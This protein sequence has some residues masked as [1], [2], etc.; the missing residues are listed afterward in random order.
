[1]P[2]TQEAQAVA[3]RFAATLNPERRRHF[4]Q[5]LNE[6]P[7]LADE[8]NAAVS[9]GRLR[10]F[11]PM[12]AGVN[13]GAQHDAAAREIRIPLSALDSPGRGRRYDP[14]ELIFSMAH[15]CRH[16][17]NANLMERADSNFQR[18]V[19]EIA[20]A[21]QPG[22]D[23][24]QPLAEMLQ[25]HRRNEASS[26]IAGYNALLSHVR[27][28]HPQPTLEQLYRANPERM[29]DFIER[30]NT[31]PPTYAPRA[32]L[33]LSPD[34][35]ITQT[36]DNIEAMG[37]HYYDRSGLRG[38]LGD[39]GPCDYQNLYA[40]GYI[41][42]IVSA[43]RTRPQ[44]DELARRTNP[45]ER[46]YMALN[47]RRLGL[48]E[49][50]LEREGL[51]LGVFGGYQ[52]YVDTSQTP[53]AWRRFD[54]TIETH[55][56]VAQTDAPE[57]QH[58]AIRRTMEAID[59]SPNIAPGAFGDDR[60]RVAAGLAAHAANENIRPDHVV[61]NDRRSDL[62]AVQG[63]L[64]DPAAV[65]S[66]PLPLAK[67]QGTDPSAAQTALERLQPAEA[68][69]QTAIDRTAQPESPVRAASPPSR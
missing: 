32:G 13:A 31:T 16:A 41:G 59:R 68:T 65:L 54:H 53:P 3:D 29:S 17:N 9:S 33:T 69:R 19:D 50:Q 61:M 4:A 7:G 44:E 64:G 5:T 38:G 14:S 22:H 12:A 21:R 27:T 11:A 10:N 62:I 25:E 49:A 24:T 67:A 42:R 39:Y 35:S 58:P 56:H 48:D 43:E 36:P 57:A 18:R 46:P 51:D 34:L 55:R 47:M 6:S 40:T 23:Y 8:I 30:S 63:K 20:A 60:L 2:L 1:M 26:H 15:E 37:R 45:Y 28:Q 52:T 66:S